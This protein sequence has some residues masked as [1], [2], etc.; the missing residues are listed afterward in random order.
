MKYSGSF[1]PQWIILK[2]RNYNSHNFR[3]HANKNGLS[4]IRRIGDVATAVAI[5]PTR[6]QRP[7]QQRSMTESY[8][9]NRKTR[10]KTAKNTHLGISARRE[11]S[12]ALSALNIQTSGVDQT[13]TIT[14]KIQKNSITNS[15]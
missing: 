3:K 1:A 12:I 8:A 7:K 9:N 14:P 13:R 4:R 6:V 10:A 5:V 2:I 11:V 15:H